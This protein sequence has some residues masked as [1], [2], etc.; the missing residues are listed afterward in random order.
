MSRVWPTYN[1]PKW[2]GKPENLPMF[3][4]NTIHFTK[5][6]AQPFPLQD[7]QL[8]ANVKSWNVS[9]IVLMSF[10]GNIPRCSPSDWNQWDK[11][12]LVNYNNGNLLIE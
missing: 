9:V 6:T 7:P 12:G 11:N 3:F 5:F 2:D 8:Q 10:L 4:K 1:D